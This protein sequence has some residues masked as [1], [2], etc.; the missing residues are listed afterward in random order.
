MM[1]REDTY[2]SQL[3]S[4]KWV[5]L[6]FTLTQWKSTGVTDYNKDGSVLFHYLSKSWQGDNEPAWTIRRLWNQKTAE[7]YLGIIDFIIYTSAF[8]NATRQNLFH[9]K[10]PW[11]N[12]SLKNHKSILHRLLKTPRQLLVGPF[13]PTVATWWTP[14]WFY[15]NENIIMN[16]IGLFHFCQQIL[17]NPAHK[18]LLAGPL[19]LFCQ[20]TIFM[21]KNELSRN[22]AKD[23]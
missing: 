16:S 12:I 22:P 6:F 10:R 11:F 21:T 18:V 3:T 23:K 7:W 13:W 14:W 8:P 5:D 17:L 4:D 19:R 20:T 15:T 9:Y 2:F 1:L